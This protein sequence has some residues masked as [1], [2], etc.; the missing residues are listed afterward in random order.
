MLRFVGYTTAGLLALSAIGYFFVAAPI[1]DRRL[2][3]VANEPPYD[4][5][6]SVRAI[7][8]RL[9]VAD[10]HNDLLLWNRDPLERYERGH[11]DLPRLVEGGVG[12]QV[13]AAVTQV[14]FGRSYQGTEAGSDQISF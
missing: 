6:D 12:L 13:F 2:N 7:H 10:L 14:P 11:S 4:V 9:M 8:E 3:R 1:A 5:A